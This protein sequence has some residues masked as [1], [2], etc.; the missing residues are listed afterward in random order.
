MSSSLIAKEASTVPPFL[1][2]CKWPQRPSGE[3]RLYL[4]RTQVHP[5]ERLSCP[6]V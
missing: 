3:P 1:P 2:L 4:N 5:S 6:R